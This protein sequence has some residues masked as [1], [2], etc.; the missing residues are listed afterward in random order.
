MKA[1]MVMFDS[2]NKKA[3]SPYGNDWIKTPNFDRLAEKSLRFENFYGGSMPCM[4]ARRELHT[5]RYNFLHRSWG[6]LE[7]FDISM[8]ELLKKSG[9]YTH[10]ATDHYHYFEE[11]GATYHGKFSSW[12]MFRG[13]EGDPWKAELGQVEIPEYVETIAKKPSFRQNWVNR[14][15]QE[16]EEDM[17]MTMTFDAGLEFIDHNNKHDQWFLQIETFDPHEP[18]VTTQEYKDIYKHA[19]DGKMCDWPPYSPVL[20]SD[21][22]VEHANYE[23]AALVT[24]CDRNLGRVLDAFDKYNLWEDTM[25]IVNT[26]HGF[27]LGEHR[28]WGKN[29]QPFYN[30]I[31]NTPFFIY[32]PRANH[33][34][35]V[36]HAL[37][38]TIDIAPTLLD[39]FGQEIPELMEGR[40]M[41]PVIDQDAKIRDTALFGMF[42]GHVNITDGQYTYMRGPKSPDNGPINEYTL[43][44]T[45]MRDFFNKEALKKSQLHEGFEF[46]E[47]MPLLKVPVG[48]F[49]PMFRYGH[50]LYD[51]VNDWGQVSRLD[52]LELEVMMINK[53]VDAMEHS[54]SPDEQYQRLGLTKGQEMT[55]EKLKAQ[56]AQEAVYSDLG[57]DL[58]YTGN[59][60]IQLLLLM[61]MIPGEHHPMIKQ[62]LKGMAG[63]G[64]IT[65]EHIRMIAD[66]MLANLGPMKDYIIQMVMNLH[67]GL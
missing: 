50:R 9:I 44:P 60:K 5:G 34:S 25:L 46:T 15:Y 67:L 42:G 41:R 55:V 1:V 2:L 3:L 39:F 29:L 31:I 6:P 11:G 35:G 58:E 10:L 16:K 40:S 49:L 28:W 36:R 62:M 23:Y 61:D 19:Y 38:Q 63:D 14:S 52:D 30:E 54:Q 17:P 66:K 13:Q 22:V 21:Q 45:V 37:A 4:P 56:R 43:M 33:G 57:L 51:V 48:N 32:D 64:C 53:L 59:S 24:M 7:P 20:E 18:F 8:P 27:L 26:D 65:S 47:G 12:E